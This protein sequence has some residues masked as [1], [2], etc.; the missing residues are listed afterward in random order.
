MHTNCKVL[1]VMGKA[2]PAA[3]PHR[4]RSMVVVPI[5]APG[6]RIVRSLLVF[7]AAWITGQTAPVDGGAIL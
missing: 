1:I 4:Q 5:E 6:V 7:G 2:D 3:A